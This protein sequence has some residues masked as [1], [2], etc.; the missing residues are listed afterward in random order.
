M[1]RCELR[2]NPLGGRDGIDKK[3]PRFIR[4]LLLEHYELLLPS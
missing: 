3:L 4:S 2:L 1:P